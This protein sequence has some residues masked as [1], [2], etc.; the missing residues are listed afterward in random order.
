MPDLDVLLVS[1]IPP[2]MGGIAQWT[3]RVVAYAETVPGVRLHHLDSSVHGRGE[4]AI[5]LDKR[6][7]TGIS[8]ARRVRVGLKRH[9]GESR[10]D[11]I[12]L[13]SSGSLGVARDLD[14]LRLARVRSIPVVYHLRFGRLPQVLSA[15]GWEA[16]LLLKAMKG[17][18]FTIV[19]DRRSQSAIAQRAPN[20]ECE[21]VPNPIDLSSVEALTAD[22]SDVE[23][24]EQVGEPYVL[25]AGHVRNKKGAS[26]L[27]RAW[28][29]GR[30]LG[31]RLEMAGALDGHYHQDL[32]SEL[33]LGG[34]INFAGDLPQ[35]ELLR[36]MRGC[37][38]FC[39]PSHTEGFP[40]AILEAMSLRR[41]VIAT[42]VGAVPEMLAGG[43]GVLVPVGDPERLSLA[44]RH[45][46][47]LA[48]QGAAMANLAYNRVRTSYDMPVVF[49]QYLAL[50]H[51][52]TGR[53]T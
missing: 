14:L 38:M 5:G 36:L 43:A 4:L 17:A 49:D 16:Q 33:G 29:L 20:A 50:W 7:A 42:P 19:L 21:V 1:P 6:I 18:R 37:G 11:V 12:H 9:L 44:L 8:N 40:N 2:P 27:I 30:P 10:I 28:A 35:S 48:D 34:S 47:S 23:E 24:R 46:A 32:A 26:D 52:A 53:S 3:Q 51:L 31:W 15:R 39:L 22:G 45:V 41:P 13:T 25:F